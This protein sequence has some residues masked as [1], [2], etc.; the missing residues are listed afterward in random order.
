MGTLEQSEEC[1]KGIHG[2]RE[3]VTVDEY[4]TKRAMLLIL[5]IGLLLMKC[6]GYNSVI[7]DMLLLVI[8]AVVGKEVL[9]NAK[10]NGE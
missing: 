4:L 10:T 3:E 2:G 5:F 9:T 8:G 7:D 6:L 1:P